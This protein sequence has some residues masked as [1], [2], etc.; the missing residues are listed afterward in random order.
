MPY[1]IMAVGILLS[2]VYVHV[3]MYIPEIDVRTRLHKINYN[4][5]QM[6]GAKFQ[7]DSA[8]VLYTYIYNT[9]VFGIVGPL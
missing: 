6:H 2:H 7:H 5:H 1:I 4:P 9:H 3:Y 8:N